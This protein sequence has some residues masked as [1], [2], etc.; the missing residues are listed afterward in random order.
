[1]LQWPDIVIQTKRLNEETSSVFDI[2]HCF[3]AMCM[4]APTAHADA[5]P[6]ADLDGNLY[7]DVYANSRRNADCNAD[8]HGNADTYQHAGNTGPHQFQAGSIAH[9]VTDNYGHRELLL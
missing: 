6:D 7:A 9:T 8:A 5:C 3:D 4:C 1:M 2:W